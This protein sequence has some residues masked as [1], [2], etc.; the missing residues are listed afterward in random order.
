MI[1]ARRPLVRRDGRNQQLPPGDTLLGVPVFLPAY[2]RSGTLLKLSL[3]LN[4]SLPVT[5]R[6]G[7]VLNVQVVLNG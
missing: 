2:T 4:Y 6:S 1:A 3:N 7:G 5:T